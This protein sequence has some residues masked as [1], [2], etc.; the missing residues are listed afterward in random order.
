MF[1]S[2]LSAHP[3]RTHI[4]LYVMQRQKTRGQ[5]KGRQSSTG[6]SKVIGSEVCSKGL[7]ISCGEGC[8]AALSHVMAISMDLYIWSA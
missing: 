7:Q 2:F 3:H 5:S 8:V 4:F 6:T 1:W